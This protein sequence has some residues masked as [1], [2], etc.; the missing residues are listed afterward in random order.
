MKLET[1]FVLGLIAFVG[2]GG[3]LLAQD[4][5]SSW[6]GEWG[7]HGLIAGSSKETYRELSVADC[8]DRRCR[9]F[10]I[11]NRTESPKAP[12]ESEFC[13]ADS[14]D[15]FFLE[16]E[17]PTKAVAHLR[18][19]EGEKCSLLF[20]RTG[21]DKLSVRVTKG[22]GDCSYFCTRNGTFAGTYPLRS[23]ERFFGIQSQV[24]AFGDD[25]DACYA[26][27]T[28]TRMAFC[29]S[30]QLSEEEHQ[31]ADL[32]DEVWLLKRGPDRR[33]ALNQIVM[34]C[35]AEPE[36]AVCL[37]TAFKQSTEALN[38]QKSEWQ[39]AEARPGDPA[40][41]KR[42]IA[43]IVGG[44][45][46]KHHNGDTSGAIYSTTDTID[47]EK[48]SD[49]SIR[50]SLQMY[51]Y[52]GH[53]CSREGEATY[54]SRGVFLDQEQDDLGDKCYFEIIPT[55]T[56]IKLEDP[57]EKCRENSCGNRGTYDDAFFSFKT[58]ISLKAKIP[59]HG[60]DG[61]HH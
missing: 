51:F 17:S 39:E 21:T 6:A 28:P 54:T 26:D 60:D 58:R 47:I 13:D 1:H 50:Y 32:F 48:A 19:N 14:N 38:R 55:T 4:A 20:E 9:I 42:K 45:R 41:A 10:K 35:N 7:E 33:S 40:E 3:N 43:A 57:T 34:N 8:L 52:N 37:S 30:N 49:R 44:Y 25:F 16:I 53:E 18:T 56:G 27:A 61:S 12:R 15:K 5:I 24:K 11:S 59:S 29:R 31:W 2:V 46:H 22:E 23:K 36:P